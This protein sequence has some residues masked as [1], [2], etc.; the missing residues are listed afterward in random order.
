MCHALTASCPSRHFARVVFSG[1]VMVAFVAVTASAAPI[2][3]PPG[4]HPGD[5]YRLAF[6][7]S[8][9]RDATSRDIAD[10]NAFVTTAAN[11]VPALAALETT[12]SAV[13]SLLDRN[14]VQTDARDNTSTNP[15]LSA[16]F[17]IYRL[18]GLLFAR[19]NSDLWSGAIVNPLEI[20]EAGPAAGFYSPV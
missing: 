8:T 7:T 15:A 14:E 5:R 11:A 10:Y 13:G 3:L 20:T 9:A 17:P 16:G 19:S 2:T 18:D 1:L 6:V 4:L 12:W